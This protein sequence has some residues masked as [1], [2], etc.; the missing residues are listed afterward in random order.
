[1]N[2]P[3]FRCKKL[4]PEANPRNADYIIARDIVSNETQPVKKPLWKRIFSK[5]KTEIKA[6]QKT[7]IICPDCY[8][9]GD[10]VIWGVHKAT[11]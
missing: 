11:G 8:R 3:C 2:I 10:R 4:I 7:A 9:P 5:E 6:V 1:M